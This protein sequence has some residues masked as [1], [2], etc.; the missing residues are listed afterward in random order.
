MASFLNFVNTASSVL[1][2]VLGALGGN[3]DGCTFTLGEQIA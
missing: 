1:S 2:D 3:S